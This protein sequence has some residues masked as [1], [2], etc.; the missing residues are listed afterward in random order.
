LLIK[1]TAV[2]TVPAELLPDSRL[3]QNVADGPGI[4]TL[5]NAMS[6]FDSRT[7]P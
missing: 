1:L 2:G 6:L 7:E 4:A 5:L 3:L